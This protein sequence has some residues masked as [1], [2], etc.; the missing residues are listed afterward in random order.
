[1]L[2][3]IHVCCICVHVCMEALSPACTPVRAEGL[4]GCEIFLTINPQGGGSREPVSLLTLLCQ[5]L[6]SQ[7]HIITYKTYNNYTCIY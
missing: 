1:M 4:E 7:L 6:V 5:L 3:Y 2:L